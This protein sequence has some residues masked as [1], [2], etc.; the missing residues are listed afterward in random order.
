MTLV[1]RSTI[2]G[3]AMLLK[4]LR[5]IICDGPCIVE[6][7]IEWLAGPTLGAELNLEHCGA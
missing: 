1:Q 4:E 5:N 3:D 6:V 2:D 7:I